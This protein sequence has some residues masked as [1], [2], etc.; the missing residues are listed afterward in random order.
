MHAELFTETSVQQ[1]D[2]RGFSIYVWANPL[3]HTK[4]LTIRPARYSGLQ[5]FEN[6]LSPMC[7]YLG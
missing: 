3:I 5:L 4:R 1:F 7:T 6:A 2:P